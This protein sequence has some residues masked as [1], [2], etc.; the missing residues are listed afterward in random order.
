MHG[1]E[2]AR[3]C[4]TEG[5]EVR[6]GNGFIE[7]WPDARLLRDVYV[8]AIWEGSG[9]VIALDVQRAIEHGALPGY[10]DDTERRAE[11][12]SSGGVAAPLGGALIDALQRVE[13]QLR[14]LNGIDDPDARTAPPASHRST[15]GDARDRR[16]ASRAGQP[17]RGG[18]GQRTPRL[19]RGP[20]PLP[21]RRR[22]GACRVRR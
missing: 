15:H 7:D 22:S 13:V 14:A 18:H 11:A 5:M 8:H 19:D 6:G 4:A 21:A 12:V 2:R 20:L 10:L 17:V 9:N 16:S 3:V 1:T